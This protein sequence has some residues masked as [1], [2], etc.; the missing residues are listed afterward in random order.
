MVAGGWNVGNTPDARAEFAAAFAALP[1]AM[2]LE[3]TAGLVGIVHADCP[4][5]SW[6]DFVG[7]LE[8]AALSVA[9]RVHLI[10]CAQ[11]NRGRADFL[12]A[13]GV[14]GVRAVVVG[15]TPMQGVTSLG[16]VLLID[17]AAWKGGNNNPALFPLIDAE[18]LQVCTPPRR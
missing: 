6:Q 7:S 2:E 14:A 3:T 15:H 17:T 18:T 11:E 10:E 12:D 9:A 16:N 1:V 8:D 13:C 5:P 4:S